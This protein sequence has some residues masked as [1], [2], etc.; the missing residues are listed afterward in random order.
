MKKNL[1]IILFFAPL[2]L[3]AQNLPSCDSLIINCCSFDS[4]GPNT[5]TLLADNHSVTEFYGYPNFVLFD[6]NMDTVAEETVTYFGIGGGFQPHTLDIV[7]P[8]VLPFNGKLNLYKGFGATLCCSFSM[9][10]PDTVTSVEDIN[11][12]N[13]FTV[14]PNPASGEV[15]VFVNSFPG[16]KN[17]VVSD[18]TGRKILSYEF[19]GDEFHFS[20]DGITSGIYFLRMESDGRN[21]SIKKFIV[22]RR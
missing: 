12:E 9:S 20:T 13:I 7:I 17:L 8:V 14:Y 6:A 18:L 15:G 22:E 10:I 11:A 21:Y 1:L 2:F 4:L 19:S 5:L 3:R 16:E